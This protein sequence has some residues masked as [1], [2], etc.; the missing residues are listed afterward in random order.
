[1]AL[2]MKFLR[3]SPV[4]ASAVFVVCAGLSIGLAA[5]AERD[6]Q[7]NA[8]QRFDNAAFGLA[9][10]VH[11]RFD[12]YTQVLIGLRALFATSP[13]LSRDEFKQYVSALQL[14]SNFPGFQV[15]NFAAYVPA[16]RRGD[17]ERAMRIDKTLP[18]HLA[19]AI[20][21]APPGDRES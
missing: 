1:M 13:D 4:L 12:D 11:D 18:A 7:R 3:N 15:L 5:F 6:V 16:E 14:E 8:Q 9:R 17:F 19:K 10:K 20:A 2:S 21:I